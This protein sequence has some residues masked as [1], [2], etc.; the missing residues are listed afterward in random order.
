MNKFQPVVL[1]V[2]KK[3]DK[4]LFTLRVDKHKDLDGKWQIPGGAVEFGEIPIVA[5]HREVKEELGIEVNVLH[6]NPHVETILRKKWQGILLCF[7]CEMKDITSRIIL[8]EEA[9]DWKWM[10][11]D[12]LHSH[13][14]IPGC[15]DIIKSAPSGTMF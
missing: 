9:T 4:Y 7:L 5:L 12:E 10:S 13:K 15:L 3:Q 11:L 14:L 2:I 8:N 1:A 6:N